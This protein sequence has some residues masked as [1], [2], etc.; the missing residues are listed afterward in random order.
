MSCVLTGGMMKTLL[1]SIVSLALLTSS[2]SAQTTDPTFGDGLESCGTWLTDRSNNNAV[3]DEQWVLGF[4]SGV[5]V[6]R[7][8]F[9]HAGTNYSS[10]LEASYYWVDNYCHAHPTYQLSIA[11]FAY[12]TQSGTFANAPNQ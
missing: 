9:D 12:F 4:L 7:L 3:D 5:V 1:M 8:G 10:D 2:A 11:A 6:S